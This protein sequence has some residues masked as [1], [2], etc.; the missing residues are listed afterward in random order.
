M[1]DAARR[2]DQERLQLALKAASMGTFVWHVAEDRGEPDRQM[3]ALFGQP[4]DGTLTLQAALATMIHPDDRA[5]YASAIARASDPTGN[6]EVREDIRVM[7]PDG[8]EHWLAVT[9]QVYFAGTPPQPTRMVGAALDVTERKAAEAA[10][11]ASEERQAFL[12]QLS[13]GLRTLQN[14]TEIQGE[15]GRLLGQRLRSDHTY[16]CEIDEASGYLLVARDFVREGVPTLAGRYP[17]A[18]FHWI[19]PAFRTR[20]RIVVCDTRTSSLIPHADRPALDALGIGAF[21]AVPLIKGER[22]VAALCV[23]CLLPREWKSEEVDLVAETAERTWAA[24]ERARSDAARRESDE[25]LRDVLASV[26]DYAI[27]TVDPDGLITSWNAGARQLTGYSTE[28]II[29]QPMARFYRVEDVLA[30]RPAQEMRAA[31]ESGHSEDES[32]RVHKDGSLLWMNEIMT[33]LRGPEGEHRGFTKVSRDLTR[34]RRAEDLL[35]ASEER[36]RLVIESAHDFAIFTTDVEALIESWNPAAERM[37]G[38]TET[39]AVG[40]HTRM[41]FTPED[42]ARGAV[43]EEFRE[44]RERGRAADERWHLRKDGSRFFASGVLAALQPSGVLTGFVKI[45]RDLTQRKQ[46]EDAQQQANEALEERVRERTSELARINSELA[47]EVSERRVAEAQVKALFG[48][49]VHAQEEERR[50]IARD[51]HDQLGQ[52]MTALRMNLDAMQHRADEPQFLIEH[53]GRTRRLA[54]ELDQNLDA[55]TWDLRP[56]ALDQMGL[57]AALA[58]LVQGWSQRFGVAAEFVGSWSDTVRLA[59]EIEANLYRL[60]QE[61]L[62]NVMK[63]AGATHVS[64]VLERREAEVVLIIEDNGRGFNATEIMSR[65]AV[66]GLGLANMRERATLAGGTCVIESSPR[67]GTTVFVRLPISTTAP[68]RTP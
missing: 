55:L 68:H 19:A 24:V 35:R 66:R 37:F 50:R 64:V 7:W 59:P 12:L 28:E 29:G 4:A 15:A 20:A 56:A 31:L 52:S 47:A 53:I 51:L 18:A 42:R 16:Y 65:S 38:W 62:H 23:T 9:A 10:L 2:E 43:D 17:L 48:R 45:A 41:I 63:H 1:S 14:P 46:L 36:F 6:G 22:L 67:Q 39:E 30:E 32:W 5:R 44:A 26:R 8:S 25:R 54:E 11:R 27:F 21:V 33:P 57:S 58:G 61:A 13:D 34:R 3:L 40:Q 60:G 49:L